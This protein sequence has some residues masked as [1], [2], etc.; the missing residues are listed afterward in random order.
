MIWPFSRTAQLVRLRPMVYFLPAL[1]VAASLAQP[2]NTP[3][4]AEKP[5]ASKP[6][7]PAPHP[8]ITEILYAVPSGD[9]G[10]ANSDGTRSATG[11]EFIELYNPHDKPIDLKGYTIT[12][13]SLGKPGQ[14]KF[15]FPRC[16]LLPG[17]CVVVFNGFESTWA[18]PVG[19]S[20]A[21][22]KEGNKKF[23]GAKVFSMKTTNSRNALSNSGDC[24][25]LSAPDGTVLHII[26]WGKLDAK[27]PAAK[28]TEEAPSTDRGSVQRE[29]A[30]GK[31][32]AH[33]A[34]GGTPAPRYSPGLFAESESAAAAGDPSDDGKE[35]EPTPAPKDD[36]AKK[37]EPGKDKKQPKGK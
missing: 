9:A 16:K 13:K 2:Q 34:S 33:P 29:S 14:L 27:L 8:L 28:L 18:G 22:P 37:P 20:T 19:D 3:P 12:D 21:A 36:P 17:Q 5:E 6:L 15:V 35:P 30:M 4:P 32:V 24:V 23:H 26:K 25:C 7:L 31:L 11:D 1:I 10:D